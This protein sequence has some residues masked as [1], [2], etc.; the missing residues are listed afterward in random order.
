MEK[1]EKVLTFKTVEKFEDSTDECTYVYN[2]D[3]QT[4]QLKE[5]V[6]KS[7]KFKYTSNFYPESIKNGNA[8]IKGRAVMANAVLQKV[9]ER[10][11]H[12]H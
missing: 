11:N 5:M 3:A 8:V 7:K 6:S 10:Q 12:R 1:G 4:I 2:V 9:E